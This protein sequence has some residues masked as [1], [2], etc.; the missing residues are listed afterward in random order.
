MKDEW[1]G[2]EYQTP[3]PKIEV[4][5]PSNKTSDNPSFVFRSEQIAEP[6]SNL[7]GYNFSE[8]TDDLEGSFSFSV[9]NGDVGKMRYDGSQLRQYDSESIFDYIKIRSVVKI[10]E[11]GEQPVFVGIIRQRKLSK[12]MTQKGIKR[13]ITFS[14][15]SII[16]CITE[17]AVSLDMRI[18]GVAISEAKNIQMLSDIDNISPLTIKTFMAGTW[19]FFKKIANNVSEKKNGIATIE[20]EDI[21]KRHIGESPDDFIS[22]TG[23]AAEFRYPI[24]GAIINAGN[25]AIVDIWKNKL[26]QPIYELYAYCDDGKPKIMARQVPFGGDPENDYSDWKNLAPYIINPLSLTVYDLDQNDEDV[27]TAFASFIAGSVKDRNFYMAVNQG[28][29]DEAVQYGK[30]ISIYGFRPLEI[31]FNGYARQNNENED[32]HEKLTEV[33]QKLNKLAAYWYSRN[34]DM[35]NGSITVCTNF[36]EPEKNPRVGCRAKFL[37][38]EFYIKKTEHSWNYGGTPTIKLTV[39][40]GFMYDESGKIKDGQ[41]GVIKNVGSKF[42]ELEQK[43]DM[44]A[45]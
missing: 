36:N 13:T 19:E 11:G 26:P 4:F 27:Y 15:K 21:I 16:S 40:R 32:E 12:Q 3:A 29:N 14:G 42:R 7:L 28:Q 30:K 22:V 20:I 10:Y 18:N 45:I 31:T 33:I 44:G 24:S 1:T 25:N 5:F 17:Y 9:E 43:P 37:D 38:G 41:D 23:T 2:T 35:F 6:A 39:S 34:D 8:S